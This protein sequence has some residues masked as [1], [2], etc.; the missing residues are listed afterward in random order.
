MLRLKLPAALAGLLGISRPA[1]PP[2]PPPTLTPHV[3][4]AVDACAAQ[5]TPAL[6]LEIPFAY[7]ETGLTE[8]GQA[9]LSDLGAWLWRHPGAR[10]TLTITP[11]PHYKRPDVEQS[12]NA[13]RRRTVETYL[14]HRGV[15]PVSDNGDGG[16]PT[17]IARLNLRGRGW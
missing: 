15:E 1:D 5:A 13:A 7:A 12:L 14:H 11:E 3:A 17:C 2:P 16:E 6:D 9:R 10:V 4:S 8:T